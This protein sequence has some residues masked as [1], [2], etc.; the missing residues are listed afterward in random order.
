MRRIKQANQAVPDAL[1]SMVSFAERIDESGE[2]DTIE[3]RA[4]RGFG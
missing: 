1:N 4:M 2:D 3:F